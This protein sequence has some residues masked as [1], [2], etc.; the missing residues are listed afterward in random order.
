M[1]DEKDSK[2]E[3]FTFGDPLP[4][5]E[6]RGLID[7]VECW[8]NGHYYEPP[9]NFQGLAK[10]RHAS[11]HHESAMTCKVNILTSCYKGHK[12]LSRQQFRQIAMDYI[13]FGNAYV[14]RR[15]NM[16]GQPLRLRPALARMVRAK[17]D[18]GYTFLTDH[19]QMHDFEDDSLFHF[20]EPD[21]NQEIYG[22]PQYLSAL[23]SIFLNEAATLFRRKYYINGAH[24]GFILHISDAVQDEK[25]I[26]AIRKALKES[27]GVGNFRNLFLY[28][29]NGKKDGVNLIPISEV[30]AKDEFLNVKN[31]SRDDVLAAHR[32]PPQL[33]SV[34]PANVGGFGNAR[35][36]A[37]VFARN[38][39]EP[40]KSVFL[41]LNMWLGEEVIRFDDYVIDGLSATGDRLASSA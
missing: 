14:E 21:I 38:E 40:L 27:K 39:V 22:V 11:V 29:P 28:T 17:K 4:V 24:A 10:A 13:I 8:F 6:G 36:A 35:D 15:E 2:V 1:T 20:K 19:F 31:V 34:L 16:L 23:Q 32:V 33:M 18:G 5:I 30:Q 7:F 41:D 26:D 9:I 37:A 12:L 3:I 25:D